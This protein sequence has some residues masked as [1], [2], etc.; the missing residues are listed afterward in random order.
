MSNSDLTL[1]KLKIDERLRKLELEHA[2]EV[3]ETKMF[4]DQLS[5]DVHEIKESVKSIIHKIDG[6]G[7]P[8][9][10]DRLKA[11]EDYQERRKESDKT[12]IKIATGAITALI[13]TIAAWLGKGILALIK[14]MGG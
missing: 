14:I 6:N 3:T 2:Q 9:I 1:E 10:D 12:I 11:I 8:G 13:I 7:S 4:R 5:K